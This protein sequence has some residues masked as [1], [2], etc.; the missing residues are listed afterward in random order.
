MCLLALGVSLFLPTLVAIHGSPQTVL[1]PECIAAGLFLA[2]CGLA[3]SSL[4]TVRLRLGWP[5]VAAAMLGVGTLG[6]LAWGHPAYSV[7]TGIVVYLG[8]FGLAYLLGQCCQAAAL[9]DALVETVAWGLLAC[10]LGQSM[11]GLI[12]LVGWADGVFVMHKLYQLVFGNVAQANHYADLIWLG[13]A[14]ALCL[15]ARRRLPLWAFAPIV[16]WLALAGAASASRG[17]LFYTAAFVALAVW[18]AWRGGAEMRHVA[19][20]LGLIVLASVA[21]QVLISYGHILNAFDVA[22]SISR[23]QDKGSNGQ[24]LHDWSVAWQA[25]RAH[26]LAGAGAGSFYRLT[27]D[28]AIAGPYQ[29][30]PMLAEHAHNLPLHLAAEIG[31]PWTLG[32]FAM[33]AI[34]FVTQLV[35]SVTPARVFALAGIMV[36][37]IHSMVEYPLWYTYFMIPFGLLFGISDSDDDRRPIV[38][39][40]RGF[41]IGLVSVGCLVFFWISFDGWLASRGYHAVNEKGRT[42]DAVSRAHTRNLMGYISRFSLFSD[43]AHNVMMATWEPTRESAP[44]MARY[45][46]AYWR[47][48]PEWTAMIQCGV[49]Y[50]AIGDKAALD[51]VSIT[52]CRAFPAYHGLAQ[53]WV[54]DSVDLG[55]L[56]FG[57]G[58][59]ACKRE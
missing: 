33:L 44:Q 59:W 42:M 5:L 52:L 18:V 17:V 6:Q 27:I 20:G 23:V 39:I 46:D 2:A 7:M 13:M 29:G 50:A 58:N 28:A 24:R 3:F 26:P 15:L 32:A 47:V 14:G 16:F 54:H 56:P 4:E 11:A 37:G 38:C 9:Q 51:G 34:W 22:S 30:F 35:R 53:E 31:L 55:G 48:R 43:Y 19:L 25:I 12:Q 10:A 40:K 21:A 36:M 49:A 1:V 8:L 45:C 41:L 57:G